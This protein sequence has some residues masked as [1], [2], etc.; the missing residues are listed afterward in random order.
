MRDD[1][2]RRLIRQSGGHEGRPPGDCPRR[3]RPRQSVHGVG[4][5]ETV[6]RTGEG[7]LRVVPNSALEE[8]EGSTEMAD[9]LVLTPGGLR[10]RSQVHLIESGAVIDGTDGRLCKLGPSS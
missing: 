4:P 7:I 9:D 8:R 2:Q 6:V 3:A 10:P 1:R 5:E